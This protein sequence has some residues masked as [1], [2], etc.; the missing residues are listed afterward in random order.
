[1]FIKG[2]T[3]TAFMLSVLCASLQA[4]S[5][6]SW[7]TYNGN[8]AGQHYSSLR[9]IN[10]SNVKALEIVWTF[11]TGVFKTPG[12]AN[13]RAAFEANPVLWQNTLYLT[14]PFDEVFALDAENGAKL[15]SYD[16]RIDRNAFIN[17]VASRGVALWHSTSRT[18]LRT[19]C[20][21]RVF[22][23]TVD[24][25]LIALDATSGEPCESFGDR[26]SVDLARDFHLGKLKWWYECT[27]PPTVVG[28]IV[29]VG[30]SISDNQAVEEPSGA[31]RGFDARSGK[32]LWSWE[33]LPWAQSEHPRTGA[34][35]TW[36]AIAA[37]P[38]YGLI[39]V[40]TGSASPD[41]Y[42]GHRPGN[43]KDADSIV[44]LKASTG[45][46]V[47]GFQIVHHDLWDYDIAAE[48]VLFQFRRRIPAIAIAT[49][50]GMVFVLNR[51]TGEPLYPV[52]ERP[53]PQSHISEEETSPTQP[54]SSLPPLAPITFTANQ[55]FG[56]SEKARKFCHDK[57]AALVNGGIFTPISTRTTLL[58]P[59]SVGGVE[60]GSPAI[61]PDTGIM[62]V[63][64]NNIP[65]DARLVPRAEAGHDLSARIKRKLSK[66][67]A[68]WDN[69]PVFPADQ[70]F[71]TPDTAGHELSTQ[72]GTPYLIFR[73]PLVGPD[74]LPCTPPPW[75]TMVAMDLNVGKK[76]WSI[77]I[78]STVAGKQT[79]TVS[80]GG[81]IVTRG[82]VIFS[83]S[84]A[85]PYLRAYDPA[86][87]QE[88]WRVKLPAAAQSTPMTYR[89]GD[90]Q[91]VVICAGGTA[92]G[93][94]Q[95]GDAVVAFALPKAADHHRPK[96]V[97]R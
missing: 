81:P 83:A 67:A 45:Q 63:N 60:W 84:T 12:A 14:T 58:Y 25:R 97:H 57:I 86:N 92:P 6:T 55:A 72:M 15:W 7:S 4:Q 28:D 52:Y 71:R 73:E 50:T 19:A 59:G 96:P 33:P 89:I 3:L 35:N 85:D 79:A 17:V 39:Y 82:N 13:S 46:R 41:F 61:N 66:W 77:A 69:I 22:L 31:V 43:N 44:A 11:H 56:E 38:K 90:R 95:P 23:A 49:K 54:F 10:S 30:S 36:S 42:G 20:S 62:Y 1:M 5:T 24:A 88:L 53:V 21:N 64:V 70:R 2:R 27:S 91:Y 87:G 48:P 47:W 51:L 32:L 34:A 80:A 78:G 37:D 74:G 8:L 65:F 76:L 18:N 16:P 26:G 75:N 93:S 40:P 68:Y 94:G 9:Q 29:I